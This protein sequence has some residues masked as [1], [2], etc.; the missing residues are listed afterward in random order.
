MIRRPAPSLPA[1][2]QPPVILGIVNVTPDSFS[3][4]GRFLHAEAAVSH[5]LR[6][7]DEGADWVDVGGESTRPGAAPVS[8]DEEITRV[9]PVIEGILQQRPNAIISIDTRHATVAAAAIAAGACIVNDVSGFADPEMPRVCAASGVMVV[10]MHMRGT[11]ET[12]QHDTH[13]DD[14][15]EEVCLGLAAS[16]ARAR[17]VGIPDERIVVDPGVGFGKALEDNPT[18]IRELARVSALGF[19]VLIGASRKRFIGALTGQTDASQRIYGSLGAALAADLAGARVL[20]VHDVRAT[21][22]A[23]AVFRAC[24]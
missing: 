7:L 12:M 10:L 8:H 11:P 21:V 1:P 4:G 6:L 17:D 3:D 2:G 18:L 22:E 14:L 23:L 16:V 20:R 15:V 5:A 9:V 13:Y 19:P 24:R